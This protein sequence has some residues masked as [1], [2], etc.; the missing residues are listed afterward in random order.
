LVRIL[1]TSIVATGYKLTPIEWD[2]ITSGG[3]RAGKGVYP[4][5]VRITAGNGET[6]TIS[7]R[8]IIY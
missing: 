1:N 3:Q 4:Y 2:G 5:M 6:S 8:M 7:G